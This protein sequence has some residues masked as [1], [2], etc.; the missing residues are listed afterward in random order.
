MG[1]PEPHVASRYDDT[2]FD[3]TQRALLEAAGACMARWGVTKTTVSDLAVE[4]GCS[5]AT[6]YRA[7]P[8][9]KKQ[10]MATYGLVELQL[11]FAEASRCAADA[12]SVGD[13]LVEVITMAA[14]GLA[15][16]RGFQFMLAHEP[17]LVLPYLGFTN[18][19]RLY[20]L[21]ADALA[22][23]FERFDPGHAAKLIELATRI[24]LSYT[25][26]PSA[27]VDLCDADQVRRLVDRHLTPTITA[28]TTPVPGMNPSTP[29]AVPA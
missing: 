16:H 2:P 6:A 3:A 27:A 8:G 19:D 5:R 12:D 22:G 17:G 23:A 24:T 7:F 28:A 14:R 26:Q 9:G 10:I 18:I 4:A 21:A 25:F 15:E 1:A 29:L 20:L 11:F 13:A